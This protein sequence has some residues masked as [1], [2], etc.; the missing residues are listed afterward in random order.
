M[1]VIIAICI[2]YI[3]M[4]VVQL[5]IFTFVEKYALPLLNSAI[6]ETIQ[7]FGVSED[8]AQDI[9]AN[10]FLQY[11][12]DVGIFAITLR[13]KLPIK[14]AERLGF[15]TK[16]WSKRSLTSSTKAKVDKVAKSST[17]NPTPSP[18]EVS[19]TA[20]LVSQ[21]TRTT[22]Q[23][24]NDV[25][26]FI[27][28]VAGV[29][30]AILYM[31]AQYIDYASWSGSAYQKTFQAFFGFFGLDPKQSLASSKMVSAAMWK[32]IY[33]FYSIRGAIGIVDPFGNADH[34]F[35]ATELA[36]VV[37]KA[38][39]AIIADGGKA[40]FDNVIA[41]TQLLIV[42]KG[43]NPV[44]PAGS[45]SSSAS[46]TSTPL[47]TKPPVEIKIFTGVVANGALGAPSEF[48]E[49][50]DDMIVNATELLDAAKNNL[51][52]YVVALPGKFYYEI[53]IVSSV[54]TKSGFVQK[55][56]AQR[57]ISGYNKDN[58]PRYKTI[59]NKFAVM[60]IGV[61]DANG[62]TVK[63]QEIVLGPVDASAFQPT[64]QQLADVAKT[65]TPE[66]FTTDIGDVKTVVTTSPVTVT[67]PPVTT[68]QPVTYVPTQPAPA[69]GT[70]APT[71][72][73]TPQTPAP[74]PVVVTP[75][76][77]PPPPPPPALTPQQIAVKNATN[78]SEAYAT[79]GGLPSLSQ[80][81][82]LYQAWGLGQASLYVGSA[83][84]NAKY[85][86]ELKRQFG[87]G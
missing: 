53:A 31:L 16:G 62:R 81:A 80:R 87:V 56:A 18:A 34:V 59:Y 51:T 66:L 26:S 42:F 33:T 76:P 77:P 65:I 74:A 12:E 3:I 55:G 47:A 41:A 19:K 23:K 44:E 69:S 32:K 29:P 46:G 11:A 58:T 60:R 15:T 13:T 75:P 36:D 25:A 64:T 30:T 79:L 73:S 78:L 24:V 57:I 63:L 45:S 35:N 1:P 14:L 86:A 4:A 39:T 6:S 71:G 70:A 40:T 50:P 48:T 84:Q 27:A 17:K 9:V 5:G 21:S 8:E 68:P 10:E 38:A 72:S 7:F 43:G 37:D 22:F 28:K 20:E 2:R 83:E 85:L 54:K 82:N 52:A 49:R 67:P 61:L